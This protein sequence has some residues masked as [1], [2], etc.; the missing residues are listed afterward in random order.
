MQYRIALENKD[1]Y[2]NK[3]MNKKWVQVAYH[4]NEDI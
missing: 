3:V 1:C 2:E 4:E